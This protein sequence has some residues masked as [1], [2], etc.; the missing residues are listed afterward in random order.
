M[1]GTEETNRGSKQ[2]TAAVQT[3]KL[4]VGGGERALQRLT[5]EALLAS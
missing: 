2:P 5:R 3:L 4:D 1:S